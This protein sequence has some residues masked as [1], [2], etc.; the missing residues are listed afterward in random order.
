MLFGRRAP[1]EIAIEPAKAEMTMRH[2]G[3]H[4]E[5]FCQREAPPVLILS[6][7]YIRGIV[8]CGDLAEKVCRP[9]LGAAESVPDSYLRSAGGGLAGLS[10]P[11]R[12]QIAG[13]ERG[14][15]G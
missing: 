14:S 10:Q 6:A 9:R 4:A 13:P 7:G 11:S 3:A 15:H 8:L 1:A 5:L 2:Q 12:K